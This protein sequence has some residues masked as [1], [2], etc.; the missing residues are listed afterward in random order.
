MNRR[1]APLN[2][3]GVGRES[4][5]DGGEVTLESFQEQEESAAVRRRMI[6]PESGD[7]LC[8]GMGD[9]VIDQLDY[10]KHK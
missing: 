2:H 9:R 4:C 6:I 10:R 7:G 5:R 8:R 3:I 1:D